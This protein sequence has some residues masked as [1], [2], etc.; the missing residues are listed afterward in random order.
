M[1]ARYNAGVTDR[2][3]AGAVEEFAKRFGSGASVAIYEAAGAFEVPLLV[4]AAAESR[5]YDAVVALGCIVKGQTIH[6]RVLGQSVTDALLD[7]SLAYTIP[8]GLGVL[9]VDSP[10]QARARAGGSK[11]NKGAEAMSA[12]LDSLEQLGSIR[13]GAPAVSSPRRAPDKTS[14]R[15]D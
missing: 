4:Q 11:G 1:V 12:A 15:Q 9:T 8:V 14:R 2:L 3:R 6:D 10:A 13:T 5:R 7:I